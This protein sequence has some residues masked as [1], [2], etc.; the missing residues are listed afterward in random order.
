MGYG[1]SILTQTIGLCQLVV[2]QVINLHIAT[3]GKKL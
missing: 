1:C 3:D 2:F